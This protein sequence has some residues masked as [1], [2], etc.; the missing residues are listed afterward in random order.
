VLDGTETDIDCGGDAC[1]PCDY[2]GA[3]CVESIDCSFSWCSA[4][5]FCEV[6]R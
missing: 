6:G 2:V 3:A 4:L 1:A 5:G